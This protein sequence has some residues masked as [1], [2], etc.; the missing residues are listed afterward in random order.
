MVRKQ[1]MILIPVKIGE[2]VAKLKTN[3]LPVSVPFIMGIEALRVM[4][5]KIDL[6][7]SNIELMGSINQGETNSGGH[8][9]LEFE[10]FSMKS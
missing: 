1:R 9:V 5:A 7:H 8:M 2:R 3:M 4:N 6:T 10:L